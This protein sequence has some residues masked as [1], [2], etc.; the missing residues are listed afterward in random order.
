MRK[1]VEKMSQYIHFFV[2]VGDKFAPIACYSRNAN[3]YEAFS[4]VAPYEQIA[5]L[6]SQKIEAVREEVTDRIIAYN[7]EIRKWEEKLRL[8]REVVDPRKDGLM[9]FLEKHDEITETIRDYEEEIEDWVFV[10]SF[11][12]FLNNAILEAEELIEEGRCEGDPL[13]YIYCGIECGTSVA[14]ED[15]RK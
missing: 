15:I 9:E 13:N 5:P 1:E 10:Q 12:T 4:H 8:I 7:G 11:C 2:R 6:T 14:P 3:I